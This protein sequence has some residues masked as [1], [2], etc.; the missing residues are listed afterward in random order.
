MRGAPK[1]RLIIQSKEKNEALDK[2]V[3]DVRFYFD[4]TY[5]LNLRNDTTLVK[6]SMKGLPN[7]NFSS[8]VNR[9][10]KFTMAI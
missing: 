10:I 8:F 2:M 4:N 7:N 9:D 1:K 3:D 6:K 5:S